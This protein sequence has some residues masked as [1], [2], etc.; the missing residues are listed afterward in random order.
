M[1][2]TDVSFDPPRDEEFDSAASTLLAHGPVTDVASSIELA[3]HRYADIPG[4][5][6]AHALARDDVAE[7]FGMCSDNR[8]TC[9]SCR[10]WADHTHDPLTGRRQPPR[11]LGGRVPGLGE[12]DID[13][14]GFRDDAV[15]R[16]EL[17][18][19]GVAPGDP[20]DTIHQAGTWE[21]FID[22]ALVGSSE[23]HHPGRALGPEQAHDWARRVLGEGVA[24]LPAD[25]AGNY[26]V[27]NPEFG[28]RSRTVAAA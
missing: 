28:R 3:L 25:T 23:D 1:N 16:T 11:T 24:F 15:Y 5:G 22:S 20:A 6:L 18:R 21:L 26:Y 8:V 10:S 13:Q 27:A 17:Q 9:Y 7:D 14:P 2:L 12:R 19:R 4:D